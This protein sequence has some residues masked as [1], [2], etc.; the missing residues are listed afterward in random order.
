MEI[1]AHDLSLS[2]CEDVNDV[3]ILRGKDWEGQPFSVY[4][5]QI[6][7]RSILTQLTYY[8]F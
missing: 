4:I 2:E 6:E 1:F 8:V 7:A 3:Y 5:N